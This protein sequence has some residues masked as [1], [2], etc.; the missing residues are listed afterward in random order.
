[1]VVFSERKEGGVFVDDP[2][3]AC[4]TAFGNVAC[5]IELVT[6]IGEEEPGNVVSTVALE[7]NPHYG[8]FQSLNLGV[9]DWGDLDAI[10]RGGEDFGNNGVDFVLAG[11]W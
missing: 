1:M 2:P 5:D 4:G 7:K 11:P 9:A 8:S 6:D 10:K 3:K